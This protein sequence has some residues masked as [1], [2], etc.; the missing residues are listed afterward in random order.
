MKTPQLTIEKS[1]NLCEVE[2]IYKNKT[3]FCDMQKITSSKD[4]VE[5][6]RNCF[7]PEKM[8]WR[9]EMI[10]LLLNRANKVLGWVKLSEG[11]T[12]GTV[13]DKK[14]IFQIALNANA[15]SI[16]L[17]HN[18]PSGNLKPSAEDIAITKEVQ[19]AG[20]ILDINVL[21]HVIL[22]EEGYYSFADE[23]MM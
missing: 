15:S 13:C 20:R 4:T 3:K 6:L 5:I 2:I 12:A 16:I 18:H 22:T 8:Q 14:V 21:D 1:A 10:L 19:A 7:N 23:G 9:E 11:G 17:S